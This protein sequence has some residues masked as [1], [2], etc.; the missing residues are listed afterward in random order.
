[1]IA[2]LRDLTFTAN[3]SQILSLNLE[4]D[5]REGFDKLKDKALDV[6][7]KPYKPKRSRDANAYL[8]V[9]CQKIAE[10]QGIGAVEVYRREIEDVG[11]YTDV[12]LP[13]D[14]VERFAAEWERKGLGWFCRIVDDDFLVG[15]ARVRCYYG[16]STYNT[17]EMSR[18]INATVDDARALG[19]ETAS[20]SE[21]ALLLDQWEDKRK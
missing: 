2:R 7:I 5:F 8:W 15:C 3:G 12:S 9:I 16:S 20:Y 17:A 10:D 18:L 6:E 4:G 1:M 11:V 21:L 19:I 13:R 14:T